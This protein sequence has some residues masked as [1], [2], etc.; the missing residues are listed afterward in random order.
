MSDE[1]ENMWKEA[2]LAEL[3]VYSCIFLEGQ[4]KPTR[5]HLIVIVEIRTEHLPNASQERY[6]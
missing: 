5:K 4:R 3:T 6:L 2:V 1:L